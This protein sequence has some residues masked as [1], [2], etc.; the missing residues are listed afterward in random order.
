[1]IVTLRP[2]NYDDLRDM[3]DDGQRYE[4]ICEELVVNPAP[5][6]EH[7]EVAANLN[8]APGVLGCLL[9]GANSSA[10]PIHATV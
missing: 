3:P 8:I 10:Q 2:L 9:D 7:Q 6:R 5:R 4:I 1:M